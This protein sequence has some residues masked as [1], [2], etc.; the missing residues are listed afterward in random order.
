MRGTDGNDVVA[1]MVIG[2]TGG[3][4]IQVPLRGGEAGSE[5]AG[6]V[7]DS[8]GAMCACVDRT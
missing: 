8:A 2:L 1:L 6:A 5:G 7:N 3:V 4:L